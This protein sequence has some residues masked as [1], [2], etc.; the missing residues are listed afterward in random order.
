MQQCGH[1]P[2]DCSMS[3]LPPSAQIGAASRQLAPRKS[4]SA[5]DQPAR[6]SCCGK[7]WPGS[8]RAR[9][10]A[11]FQEVG[12]VQV[13]GRRRE[14][15]GSLRQT[16]RACRRPPR[17][18]A[19][20][21]SPARRRRP[22]AGRCLSARARARSPCG[23]RERAARAS[24]AELLDGERLAPFVVDAK[25]PLAE[26]RPDVAVAAAGQAFEI[27]RREGQRGRLAGALEASSGRGRW[28]AA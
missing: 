16:R 11:P 1:G 5:G 15:A 24:A 13:A 23:R 25:F 28:P 17:C 19:G 6:R 10:P 7:L 4:P 8:Q 18:G 20:R 12:Q 2:E 14:S 9:R 26:G 27:L 22:S 21:N 3:A